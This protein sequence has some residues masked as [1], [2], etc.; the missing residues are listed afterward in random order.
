MSQP[1][2]THNTIERTADGRAKLKMD[3][4]VSEWE[5]SQVDYLLAA[6]QTGQNF[7]LES[8]RR[9]VKR[10]RSPSRDAADSSDMTSG[11]E[12]EASSDDES[13]LGPAC[14]KRQKCREEPDEEGQITSTE[15]DTKTRHQPARAGGPLVP[16]KRKRNRN[17]NRTR[18]DRRPALKISGVVKLD[19][20]ATPLERSI[21]NAPAFC[22]ATEPWL[23]EQ[24]AAVYRIAA[25][26]WLREQLAERLAGEWMRSGVTV[27]VPGLVDKAMKDDECSPFTDDWSRINHQLRLYSEASFPAL[28]IWGD[29]H[30][31]H[32]YTD[33]RRHSLDLYN[34]F[35][36]S[37]RRSV[38]LMVP[39]D[40]VADYDVSGIATSLSTARRLSARL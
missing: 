15:D 20:D 3:I 30:G 39:Q 21:V 5:S 34:E 26:P 10:S 1:T 23:R 9:D 35:R 37:T 14:S 28:V 7:V 6:V 40:C 24:L 31:Q 4:D 13:S 32:T 22:I 8:R 38:F 12:S 36:R 19:A 27:V 33:Y 16:A 2:Q 29:R 25:E 11:A 17:R 18:K